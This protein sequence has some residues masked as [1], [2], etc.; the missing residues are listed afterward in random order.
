MV[1]VFLGADGSGKTTIIRHFLNKINGDWSE[2]KYVHFRPSYILKTNTD[3][4]Q[5]TN[6]HGGKQP[7]FIFSMI[8]LLYFVLEYNYAFWF[9]YRKP[10]QLVLFDRYYYDVLADPKRVKCSSPQW[11]L[12]IIKRFIPKPDLVFYLHA[13]VDEIYKRKKE[14]DKNELSKILFSYLNLVEK[15]KFYKIRT[16]D[17]VQNSLDQILKIYKKNLIK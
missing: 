12:T 17:S 7:G 11:I 13:P 1:I 4:G 3:N 5:V 9:F 15:Y 10:G 6:P 14:I 8:K 2:I 16:D